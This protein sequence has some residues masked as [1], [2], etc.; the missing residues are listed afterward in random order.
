[1]NY[2]KLDQI[3]ILYSFLPFRH[4]QIN[5]PPVDCQTGALS[6]A[7][8]EKQGLAVSDQILYLAERSKLSNIS[9]LCLQGRD[10][11]I[12]VVLED[13]GQEKDCSRWCSRWA[14]FNVIRSLMRLTLC[15]AL[16]WR[17]SVRLGVTL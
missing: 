5:I 14:D 9:Q 16:T 17:M 8:L 15:L 6:L 13:S 3:N 11:P 7:A 1:M 12:S 10:E 4:L 2:S